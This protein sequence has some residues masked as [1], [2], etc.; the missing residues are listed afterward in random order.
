M[1][2]IVMITVVAVAIGMIWGFRKP[3]GYCRMSSVE[4]QGL[5]NRVWSGL[6]N[7]AVLGGIALVITTILL[8]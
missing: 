1:S 7:G 8:G 2:E 3:A 5:S 6:I 4:Q